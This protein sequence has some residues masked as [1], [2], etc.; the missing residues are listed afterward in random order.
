MTSHRVTNV[1]RRSV[2]AARRAA[3]ADRA[4]RRA[5]RISTAQLARELGATTD[6]SRQV[7]E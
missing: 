2:T 3:A 6:P 4:A 1:T 7:T 5:A